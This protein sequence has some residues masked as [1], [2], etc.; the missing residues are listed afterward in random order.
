MARIAS[1][2]AWLSDR[3]MSLEDAEGR[4]QAPAQRRVRRRGLRRHEGAREAT[5]VRHVHGCT[6]CEIRRNTFIFDTVPRRCRARNDA[7]DARVGRARRGSY[8]A[9]ELSG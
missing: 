6:V 9:L 2:S 7:R 1:R 5:I 3:A 4:R 8:V